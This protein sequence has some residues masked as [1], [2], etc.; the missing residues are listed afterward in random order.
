MNTKTLSFIL[1]LLAVAVPATLSIKCFHCAEFNTTGAS[2]TQ[3]TTILA[4]LKGLEFTQCTSDSVAIECD[5]ITTGCN[6]LTGKSKVGGDTYL[7]ATVKTC[8]G[9]MNVTTQCTGIGAGAKLANT[10]IE[11]CTGTA[12]TKDS[13]NSASTTSLQAVMMLSAVMLA[14][15]AL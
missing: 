8:N 1:V 15:F 10:T 3:N 7:N 11:D 6:S 13:C 14:W 5:N 2:D 9:G 4:L 12:C